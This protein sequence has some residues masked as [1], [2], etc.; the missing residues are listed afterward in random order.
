MK[1]GLPPIS[2]SQLLNKNY[3]AQ[4]IIIQTFKIIEEGEHVLI[5]GR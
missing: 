2:I 4:I 3:L 5:E 1:N